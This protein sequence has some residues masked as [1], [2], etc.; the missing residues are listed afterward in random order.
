ADA[1]ILKNLFQALF[2]HN[3]ILIATSNF[4]PQQLYQG[5][6]QRDQFLPF[7]D[8]LQ[9]KCQIVNINAQYDYRQADENSQTP[10]WHLN[11]ANGKRN[12]TLMFQR[13]SRDKAT[14]QPQITFADGRVIDILANYQPILLADFNHLCDT[15]LAAQDYLYLTDIFDIFFISNIPKLYQED[16][17]ALKRFILLIDVLYSRKKHLICLAQTGIDA[18]YDGASHKDEVTRTISRLL[19]MENQ[20]WIMQ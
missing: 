17:N 2:S 4:A 9:T 10:L 12:F 1:M 6:I 3:I 14:K 18:I 19:E 11:D 16:R 15:P 7:I 5:G 20:Q 13:Y 8:L